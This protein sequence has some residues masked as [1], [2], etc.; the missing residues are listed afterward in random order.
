MSQV[1]PLPPFGASTPG[2]SETRIDL[3][4]S[5]SAD[6][7]S[8]SARLEEALQNVNAQQQVASTMSDEYAAGRQ[9]DLHGTMIEMSKAEISLRLLA[10]V[11]NRFIEAYREVM[12][13]G[14]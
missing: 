11:R 2:I 13:M 8:F 12:R 7:P 4:S 3:P 5:R 1:P 14:S 9:N 10:N 6:G